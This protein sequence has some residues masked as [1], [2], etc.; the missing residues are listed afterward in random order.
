MIIKGLFILAVFVIS[1]VSAIGYLFAL[2]MLLDS[3]T[4]P[5]IIMS[6]LTS[7]NII[8]FIIGLVSYKILLQ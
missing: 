1:Y 3:F 6:V 4:H 2:S 7:F 5:L 8:W